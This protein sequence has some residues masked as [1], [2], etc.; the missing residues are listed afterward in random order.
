M[1]ECPYCGKW[2]KTKRGLKQHITKAHTFE[3][4]GER[5]L[6]PMTFDP[7][8]AAERRAERAKKRKK[9]K[10]LFDLFW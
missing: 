8:G 6:D 7:I 9:K 4:A 2:F 5:V 10:G 1:P 3:F